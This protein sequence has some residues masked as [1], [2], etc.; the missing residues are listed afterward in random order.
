MRRWQSVIDDT[1][2]EEAIYAFIYCTKWRFGRVSRIPDRLTDW[3][4]TLK[5]RATQLL[6]KYKSG[7]LVTQWETWEKMGQKIIGKIQICWATHYTEW[8]VNRLD[9]KCRLVPPICQTNSA[10]TKFTPKKFFCFS[11]QFV[12]QFSLC[13]WLTRHALCNFMHCYTF[14]NRR[15]M[16]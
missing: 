3:Q 10:P 1:G 9:Q 8:M 4:T 16:E 15:K 5:D 13:T 2:S 11:S 14:C 12:K 6:K 7:A